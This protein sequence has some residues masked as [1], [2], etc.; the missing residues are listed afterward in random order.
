MKQS[1]KKNYTN[2][3]AALLLRISRDDGEDGE[4]NSIQNQKQL[5]TK[6][7][8]EYGYTNILIYTDDGITGTTM[9][10]PGFQAMI[11][12]IERGKIQAVFVKD[13]SR[14]GRNYREVGYYTEEFFP[15]HDVRFIS[16]S[17]G[18]DTE[19]GEDDLA[20][21]RN[22]MNEW[23]AKDISKKRRIVNKM[24]GN[25]G[26]PL[27]PPPYGYIKDPENPKRWI[28]DEE[29][30]SI[31]R[32]IFQ[33]TLDGFGLAEIAAQ[34]DKDGIMTPTNYWLSK[35]VNRG[36]KKGTKRAT[37]WNH[38]TVAKILTTQEYCGDVI[39]FKTYSKSY[40]MK[41]RI[42]NDE[43]NRAIF[44]GV[45]EPIIERA[46]FEKVKLMRGS[47]KKSTTVTPERSIFSGLLKCADCGSNLNFH[48]NQQNP[49]IKYF[50]CSNH[51]SGRGTCPSTHYIRLDFLEQVVLQEI[52]RLTEFAGRYEDEFVK[53]I[54][55][56]SMTMAQAEQEAKQ[57][58]LARLLV[59]DKELDVLF[60]RIYEDNASGKISDERFAKMSAKYEQEQGDLAKRIKTLKAE[61]NKN[62]GQL[63]TADMFLEIV[64]RYTN[65]QELTQRMVTELIDHIDVYHAHRENGEV[66]QEIKIHYHCIG[67]FE[68]PDWNNIPEL[69]VYIRTR[70]GVALSYAP[71]QVAV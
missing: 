60:E 55:G 53:A 65:A 46:V 47:R 2:D 30:A 20:P 4:S 28:I 32:R 69:A 61:L 17:D 52:Q 34:L 56:H 63:Y 66:T 48:F 40:K 1:S 64:R 67:T 50:N 70:K 23:Y 58:E 71:A 18:I 3:T 19:Q 26:E 36:G 31:V 59:R 8:K 43:E 10:R 25:A 33:M 68:V 42:V 11:R 16:V 12:D 38:S 6:L 44:Y 37:Y 9:N 57:S 14:L 41:R 51:N 5:L 29:A 13:L 54:I 49:S 24:K 39:N 7:A 62:T 21:F 22:I 35:G 45:H 27:S 15:E